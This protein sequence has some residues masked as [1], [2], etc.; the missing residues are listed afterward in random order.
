MSGQFAKIFLGCL[1]TSELKAHLNKSLAWKKEQPFSLLKLI[2]HQNQDYFGYFLE[3]SE[4]SFEDIAHKEAEFYQ[5]LA[6][7][8]PKIIAEKVK[9]LLFTEL[10]LT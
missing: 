8:C 3:Q 6:I 9:V 4:F 2:H 1:L 5:L 7:Y 10:F